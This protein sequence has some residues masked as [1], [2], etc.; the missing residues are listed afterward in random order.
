MV[1]GA[2]IA[3]S[4]GDEKLSVYGD[5]EFIGNCT[6]LEFSPRSI[7]FYSVLFVYAALFMGYCS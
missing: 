4:R 2:V 3:S 1:Y 6:L 5:S 7:L